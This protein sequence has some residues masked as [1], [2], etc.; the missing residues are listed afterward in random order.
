MYKHKFISLSFINYLYPTTHPTDGAQ[1]I[2]TRMTKPKK[3][4]EQKRAIWSSILSFLVDIL[5]LGLTKL[6]SHGKKT[7]NTSD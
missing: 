6:L 7:S 2:P 5:T 1:T 3:T 4:P